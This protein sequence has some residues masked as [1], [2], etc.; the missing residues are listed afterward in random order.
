MP[1]Q[2]QC[3]WCGKDIQVRVGAL[4]AAN[5]CS[6]QCSGQWRKGK[7][8]HSEQAKEQIRQAQFG[9]KRP[10]IAELARKRRGGLH[11]RWK[12]DKAVKN[13]GRHRA[14]RIYPIQP[15]EVCEVTHEQKRI[16]RHHKDGNTLNNAADNIAFLC[17]KHHQ[18]EHKRMKERSS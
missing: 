10:H 4:R 2:T 14:Q 11:P 8:F 16:H 5:F 6:R 18:E 1:I 3:A 15:C 17:T 9:L 7:P 13:T 12:G